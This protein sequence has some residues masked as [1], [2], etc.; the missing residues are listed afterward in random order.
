MTLS[1]TTNSPSSSRTGRSNSVMS[2]EDVLDLLQEWL[3]EANKLARTQ[4]LTPSA[5]LGLA[6]GVLRKEPDA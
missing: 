3:T 2:R 1:E 6:L 4:G 5:S